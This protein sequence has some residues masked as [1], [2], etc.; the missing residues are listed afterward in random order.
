[1]IALAFIVTLVC[2]RMWPTL[3][4]MAVNDEIAKV[5]MRRKNLVNL[6]FLLLLC[7][8]VTIGVRM[9]G[10][11]LLNALLIIPA[12]AVR[13][14]STSP[15]L[16]V[17]LATILGM[18]SITGGIAITFTWDVPAAPACVLLAGVAFIGIWLWD[19]MRKKYS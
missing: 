10:V 16:M 4:M 11:L 14:L 1:M 12:A 2:W 6:V 8:Y 7:V 19:L 17:V 13:P 15:W 18:I 3:V 5:E 9:V